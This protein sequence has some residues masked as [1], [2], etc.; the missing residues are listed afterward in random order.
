MKPRSERAI[1][2]EIELALG[3]ERD[4]LLLRNSVGVAQHVGADGRTSTLRYGL[5]SGSPDLVGMLLVDGYARWFCLEVKAETGRLSEVQ[6]HCH[7]VWRSFG[8]FIAV[9]RSA[10]E[11]RA[12]LAMARRS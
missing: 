4:L 3:A 6:E 1:L 12:A 10:D 5:G 2:R 8:A 11:A 7:D 9:V